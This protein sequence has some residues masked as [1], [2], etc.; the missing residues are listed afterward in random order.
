MVLEG[1]YQHINGISHYQKESL[2]FELTTLNIF[3]KLPP[4][5]ERHTAIILWEVQASHSRLAWATKTPSPK[6]RNEN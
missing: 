6:Q 2:Y 1:R 5:R 4:L 3:I